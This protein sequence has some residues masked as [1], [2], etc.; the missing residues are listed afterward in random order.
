MA[1][2]GDRA[3]G[4]GFENLR[5]FASGPSLSGAKKSDVRHLEDKLERLVLINLAMWTLIQETTNLTEADL[6]ER[7]AGIDL[8]DGVEDGKVTRQVA[9]C[10]DCGRVMSPKHDRCLYCGANKLVLSAFDSI[11]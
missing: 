9:K 1:Y 6:L 2:Y 5:N 10:D 8:M 3:S 11:T 4:M 7:V